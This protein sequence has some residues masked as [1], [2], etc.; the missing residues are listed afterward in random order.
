MGKIQIGRSDFLWIKRSLFRNYSCFC[1]TPV[2]IRTFLGKQNQGFHDA[3][4]QGHMRKEM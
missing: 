3:T 4:W 1:T 2:P